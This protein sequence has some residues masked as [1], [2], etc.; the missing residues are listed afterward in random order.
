MP[1]FKVYLSMIIQS[2]ILRTICSFTCKGIQ[3]PKLE[4]FASG[5]Q[6]SAQ[7][8]RKP[9]NDWNLESKFH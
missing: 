6:N 1:L 2:K 5:I 3:I 8:M 7:G 9:T 4:I